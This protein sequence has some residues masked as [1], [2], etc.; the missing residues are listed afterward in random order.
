[1]GG[2]GNLSACLSWVGTWSGWVRE[3][4]FWMQSRWFGSGETEESR[5]EG[6]ARVWGEI[7]KVKRMVRKQE[8]T[9]IAKFSFSNENCLN[10]LLK[11]TEVLGEIARM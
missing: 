5:Q 6:L 9:Q 11:E 8:R 7:I 10:L 1:M 2:K 3:R 4:W